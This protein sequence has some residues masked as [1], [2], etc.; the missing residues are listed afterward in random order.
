MYSRTSHNPYPSVDSP[1]Y[2]FS[3]VM[4]LQ[5][6]GKKISTQESDGKSY[7]LRYNRSTQLEGK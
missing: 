3:G 5:G 4:G 7:F 1:G 2:G 6:V